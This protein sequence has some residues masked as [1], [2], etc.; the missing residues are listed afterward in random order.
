MMTGQRMNLE[1]IDL[2][3][4][5]A[6]DALA[7]E[8]SVTRAAAKLNMSQPAMS[9]AL[10]RLRQH[11]EDPLFV[12]TRGQMR[13]TPRARQLS[14]PIASAIATLREALESEA[15]FRPDASKRTFV[16]SAT[17]YVEAL[18]LGK[19]VNAVRREGPR[20]SLRTVRP[21]QAFL[22]PDEPLRAKE[23]DLA[24]GLFPADVRPR[25]ELLAKVLTQDRIVGVVR[26]RHP[27]VGR[28]LTLE[29]MV[30]LPQIRILFPGDVGVGLVDTLL[31]SM[32]R[33][34]DVALTIASLV[35]VPSIV[36]NSD[37]LGFAP[38]QL[39]RAW[40]GTGTIRIVKLPITMPDLPLTMVWHESRQ[41]DPAQ[42]WLREVIA[43]ECGGAQTRR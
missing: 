15:R 20:M 2:N 12:R 31:T 23:V 24:L 8:S 30:K 34:R 41:A 26:V 19:I 36:A 4:L 42:T 5:L 38:E 25:R 10:A 1:S 3:L 22:P 29:A 32:G 35:A 14:R 16:I 33:Q 6:F 21:P 37:L 17:D 39:A 27:R 43:R 7:T 11:F 9:G 28:A 18:H 13:A 40:M